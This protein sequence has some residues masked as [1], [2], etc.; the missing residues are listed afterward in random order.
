[1]ITRIFSANT[2]SKDASA[3]LFTDPEH[4]VSCQILD[5]QSEP[6]QTGIAFVVVERG[7]VSVS[8]D[9]YEET[10]EPGSA[11]AVADAGAWSWDC[12]ADA[13]YLVM[14]TPNAAS[15]SDT[16]RFVTL[17]PGALPCLEPSTP[18]PQHLLISG[19][20]EQ[21]DITVLSG[22]EGQCNVGAWRTTAYH[23]KAIAFPKHEVMYLLD[24]NLI[25]SEPEGTE[26]RFEA[27]DVFLMTKDTVCDWKTDG[28]EKI[29]CTFTPRAIS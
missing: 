23:R 18:T 1:M 5:A 13:R 19:S 29:Y 28:L 15:D 25:L 11:F 24:G 8:L 22:S 20:P 3:A 14:S 2:A 21:A 27:G 10:V 17:V 9:G 16:P 6:P 26:H 4:E 7:R 12:S